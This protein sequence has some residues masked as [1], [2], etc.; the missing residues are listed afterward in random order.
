MIDYAKKDT[1]EKM[2]GY[3]MFFHGASFV[4]VLVSLLLWILL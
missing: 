1:S 4:I 3:E 2:N